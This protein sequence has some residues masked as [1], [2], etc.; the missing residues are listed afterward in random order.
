MLED[1]DPQIQQ[2]INVSNYQ[3]IMQIK[4]WR[5]VKQTF[6]LL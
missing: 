4:L 2:Y 6:N 3:I 1:M 5:G